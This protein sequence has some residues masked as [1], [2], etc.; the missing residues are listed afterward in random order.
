MNLNDIYPIGIVNIDQRNTNDI[1]KMGLEL[2]H[3]ISSLGTTLEGR[4]CCQQGKYN[5]DKKI[6]KNRDH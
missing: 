6:K 2:D 3:Q 5:H 1:N 4:R